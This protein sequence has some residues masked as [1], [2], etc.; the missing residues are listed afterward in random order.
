MPISL[1]IPSIFHR[2]YRNDFKH[3]LDK[4]E[5]RVAKAALPF[6][7]LYTPL[8]RPISLVTSALRVYH[9]QNLTD[10]MISISTFAAF[11]LLPPIGYA[12][13]TLQ[14]SVG[15]VSRI[16]C[17]V[18][19]KQ[20]KAA[21]LEIVCL[22][23]NIFY[24]A[25][26]ITCNVELRLASLAVQVI[27]G[28]LGAKLEFQQDRWLEGSAALIMTAIQIKIGFPLAQ[29][30]HRKWTTPAK[31]ARVH[32]GK[33]GEHWQF[34]SDHLPVGAEVK[35]VKVVSWN[36]LN[37]NYMT[38]VIDS[39]DQGLNNS[40]ITTLHRE[41]GPDGLTAR[42]QKIIGMVAEMAQTKDLIA[43]QECSPLF[44]SRLLAALPENWRMVR[45][46]ERYTLDQDA[47]IYRAD[48]L[49]YKPENSDIAQNAF[50]SRPDK[51]V[52]NLF[53]E[54]P[55]HEPFRVFNTHIP[56]DP[57]LPCK[58]EFANYLHSAVQEGETTVVLGDNNFEREHMQAAY[59]QAG[60]CDCE[61]E[62]H[63]P[64][65]TNVDPITKESKGIDHILV[66]NA[67]SRPLTRPEIDTANSGLQET[68]DLLAAART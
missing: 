36:V 18:K 57:A 6:L 46:T 28:G 67:D 27:V 21:A 49:N 56:G 44:L 37:S 30:V 60:F 41:K 62:L 66:L 20:V 32:V 34:P 59:T 54:T 51:L 63:S 1:R 10:R 55:S 8:V 24:L 5:V 52:Q 40:M 50:P 64:W 65:R 22:A 16:C 15:N 53:F 39:D 48:A 9:N 68:I 42:E 47:V 45:S 35:G 13:T 61:M 11:V 29:R 7:A 43:L 12:I 31:V 14:D 4:Y 23:N 19:D 17:Y 33:L 26:M 3:N 38:W 58:Q 2:D 25:T